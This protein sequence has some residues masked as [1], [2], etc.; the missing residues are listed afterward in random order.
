MDWTYVLTAIAAGFLAWLGYKP[1]ELAVEYFREEGLSLG[2]RRTRLDGRWFVAWETKVEGEP[3]LN[4]EELVFKQR[5]LRIKVR[6]LAASAE[7]P[8]GGYLWRGE[9]RIYDREYLIGW[10]ESIEPAV[11]ARGSLYFHLNPAGRF[12]LGRW[13]GCSHDSPT[14]GGSAVIG[15]SRDDALAKLR[16]AIKHAKAAGGK[17]RK[18][19]P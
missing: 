5:G 1:V 10:Y 16:A 19:K 15:E 18:E 13:A 8:R 17:I 11:P 4:T 2:R 12:L 14:A 9:L 3:V 7:N 6:N